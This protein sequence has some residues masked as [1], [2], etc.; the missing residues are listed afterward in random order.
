LGE[1]LM[2]I[3]VLEEVASL[4]GGM[5]KLNLELKIN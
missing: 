1:M 5:G 4:W 2:R 3:P